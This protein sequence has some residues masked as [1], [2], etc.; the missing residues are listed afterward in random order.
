MRFVPSRQGISIE[1]GSDLRQCG[2]PGFVLVPMEVDCYTTG[3]TVRED[4]VRAERDEDAIVTGVGGDGMRGAGGMCAGDRWHVKRR[5]QLKHAFVLCVDDAK[6]RRALS[7]GGP[8]LV[9]RPQRAPGRGGVVVIVPRIE[10]DFVTDADATDR[11]DIA[12]FDVQ[13]H[14]DRC[15]SVGVGRAPHAPCGIKHGV[16]SDQ[17]VVVWAL[18]QAGWLA[19]RDREGVL[20]RLGERLDAYDAAGRHVYPDL[21]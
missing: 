21:R 2:D 13:D 9:E 12:G 3:Q 1:P 14:L 8:A 6:D 7:V 5:Y 18:G 10:P 4:V 20:D 11:V 16:A 15:R 19:E 17:E